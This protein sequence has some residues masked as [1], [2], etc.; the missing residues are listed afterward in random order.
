MNNWPL[1]AKRR[2][3]NVKMSSV[4]GGV[5]YARK[6]IQPEFEERVDKS[7]PWVTV[8]SHLAEPRDDKQCSSGHICLSVPRTYVRFL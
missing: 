6:G 1:V 3:N 4:C 2:H 8:W 7:V 5:L